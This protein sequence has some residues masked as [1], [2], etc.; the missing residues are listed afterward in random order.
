MMPKAMKI[1]SYCLLQFYTETHVHTHACTEPPDTHTYRA[2]MEQ[3]VIRMLNGFS[4]VVNCSLYACISGEGED[5]GVCMYVCVRGHHCSISS[6]LMFSLL[7][8]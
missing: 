7:S 1:I 3:A 5:G 6:D 4:V 8:E 2:A